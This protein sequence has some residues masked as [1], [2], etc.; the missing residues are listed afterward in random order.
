MAKVK[1]GDVFSCEVCGII[2][3][4]DES[5]GC[6]TCDL[7][8]CGQ[9]MAKGKASAKKARKKA[10]ELAAAKKA[11][12]TAKKKTATKAV[13]KSVKVVSNPK[14]ATKKATA[15]KAAAKPKKNK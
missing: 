12:V 11:T 4:V 6:A 9:P 3:A 2:L 13:G 5:C 1:K 14:S 8:C 15:K 10:S 7:I